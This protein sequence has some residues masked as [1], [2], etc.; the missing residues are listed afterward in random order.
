MPGRGHPRLVLA[1]PL[2]LLEPQAPSVHARPAPAARHGSGV[3]QRW[4]V[5]IAAVPT[6]GHVAAF[7]RAPRC[8]W[9]LAS[10]TP[11]RGGS[12]SRGWASGHA[13]A[14]FPC[15]SGHVSDTEPLTNGLKSAFSLVRSRLSLVGDTGFEPVSRLSCVTVPDLPKKPVDLRRKET[16]TRNLTEGNG[17]D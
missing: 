11:G 12:S 6:R 3:S 10:T 2:V 7:P 16:V 13:V 15:P 1:G 8:C 17:T 5:L 14:P 9:G 4:A